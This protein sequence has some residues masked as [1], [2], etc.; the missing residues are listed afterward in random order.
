MEKKELKEKEAKQVI[1]GNGAD[2]KFD[3]PTVTYI[4]TKCG[5]EVKVPEGCEYHGINGE[6][7]CVKCCMENMPDMPDVTGGEVQKN[8]KR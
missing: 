4:C 5:I 8:I 1:G 2:T 7:L 6:L 3:Y